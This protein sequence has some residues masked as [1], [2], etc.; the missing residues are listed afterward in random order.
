MYTL[1]VNLQDT[2]AAQGP[3]ALCAGTHT[4]T[5]GQGRS[6]KTCDHYG[7]TIRH[8]TPA[9]TAALMN[10]QL[11][12]RGTAHEVWD[13][14][15]AI[16]D[17]EEN[18]DKENANGTNTTTP[19]RVFNAQNPADASAYRDA[20][21]RVLFY[22]TFTPAPPKITTSSTESTQPQQRFNKYAIPPF[23]ATFALRHYLW[24]RTA[25]QVWRVTAPTSWQYKLSFDYFASTP[26]LSWLWTGIRYMLNLWTSFTGY[27]SIN[28]LHW[29]AS[30]SSQQYQ[31]R[32]WNFVEMACIHWSMDDVFYN[33]GPAHVRTF[34]TWLTYAAMGLFVLYV[35]VAEWDVCLWQQCCHRR[36]HCQ[37]QQSSPMASGKNTLFT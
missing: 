10:S 20:T 36:R 1:F 2:R 14:E 32:G 11:Y 37:Q 8:A 27:S 5:M 7:K 23:G 13:F 15:E 34:C 22:M 25:G 18:D 33:I 6:A 12:H 26:F 4:C 17:N 16:D 31:P 29:F 3:T 9:G 24:G 35:I 19:K 21:A 30:S 28:P